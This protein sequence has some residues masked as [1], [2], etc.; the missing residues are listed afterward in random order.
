MVHNLPENFNISDF[1]VF[2]FA[3]TYRGFPLPAMSTYQYKRHSRAIC[4]GSPHQDQ[5]QTFTECMCADSQ[6]LPFY[7][8][9]SRAGRYLLAVF[10]NLDP[11]F[12]Y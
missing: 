9:L 6:P 7:N 2:H 10:S 1:D 5:R 11:I 3:L 8:K 4:S 12:L